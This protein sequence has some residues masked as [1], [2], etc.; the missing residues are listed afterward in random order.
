MTDLHSENV[1]NWKEKIAEYQNKTGA[2]RFITMRLKEGQYDWP[3]KI[4]EINLFNRT[5]LLWPKTEEDLSA[6]IIPCVS[7]AK[8]EEIFAMRFLS[9]LSW[10]HNV[11][12]DHEG[13]WTSGNI[14]SCR[15]DKSFHQSYRSYSVHEFLIDEYDYLPLPEDEKSQ[16]ALALYREAQCLSN[17]NYKFLSF[18]KILNLISN[19]GRQQV[20]WINNNIPAIKN[21]KA[22]EVLTELQ[23][24]Y[25]DV[26]SYLYASGRCAVA[27]AFSQPLVNPDKPADI[28]RLSGELPLIKSLAEL[29]IEQ[30]F[31]V[32]SSH[33]IWKEHLYELSGFKKKIGDDLL[34]S[35]LEP[36]PDKDL[37]SILLS[38]EKNLPMMSVRLRGYKIKPFE[39][40]KPTIA[41]YDDKKILLSCHSQNFPAQVF[42]GLNFAE[43]RLE[44]Y[45]SDGFFAEDN[46]SSEIAKIIADI[47]RFRAALLGN[48]VFEVWEHEGALLGRKDAYIPVNIDPSRTGEDWNKIA[49]KYDLLSVERAN[50][51]KEV[52]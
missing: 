33:T 9:A 23:K 20:S 4:T 25:Q 2:K 11:G 10:V 24:Q 34:N 36:N 43:E 5:C 27:H 32:L 44:F 7:D 14:N 40:L 37:K 38:I 3:R 18:F 28:R 48:G 13:F 50:E 39:N 45:L 12:I 49:E 22:R 31:K 41:G 17:N 29:M 8:E 35:F 6:I 52:S 19:D 26:G 16:L 21:H 1:N 15:R 51:S 47:V 46:G 30:E 42:V